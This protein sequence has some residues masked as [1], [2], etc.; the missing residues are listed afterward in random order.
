MV[1]SGGYFGKYQ[2]LFTD[3]E[4]NNCLRIYN[5][6]LIAIP[7]YIFYVLIKW[8]SFPCSGNEGSI[9]GPLLFIIYINDLSH[10]AIF[11]NIV[12]YADDTLL[13]FAVSNLCETKVKLGLD[14]NNL[15]NWIDDN[16]IFLNIKNTEY[17][18]FGTRQRL[19]NPST[20]CWLTG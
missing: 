4:E 18:S 7:K 2:P 5:T 8:G 10:C 12:L 1:N 14:V 19:R 15:T 17:A 9:L 13:L 11:W 6:H 20:V 16:G 3:T